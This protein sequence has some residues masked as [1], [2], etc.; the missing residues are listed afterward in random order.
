MAPILVK[1]GP[2]EVS[3]VGFVR[4]AAASGR[5]EESS[6]IVYLKGGVEISLGTHTVTAEEAEYDRNT[7]EV[8]AHGNVRVRPIRPEVRR[9]VSQFGIK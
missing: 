1:G 7:G 8:Q 4:G 9:G 3:F 2:H 5:I 6:G